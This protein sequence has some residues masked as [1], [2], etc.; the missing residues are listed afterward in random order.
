MEY[1][2]EPFFNLKI[3]RSCPGVP[4]EMLNPKNTWSNKRE[5]DKTA[6]KLTKMFQE[7][8][9]NMI[10][11]VLLLKLDLVFINKNNGYL[12]RYPFLYHLII[13]L[14]ICK[15]LFSINALKIS[16]YCD[17]VKFSNIKISS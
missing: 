4:A 5:Y 9:K 11:L 6:K 13:S 8:F 10:Y 3:P 12:M 7:N 14:I 15:F 1:V 16:L 17:N 2:K